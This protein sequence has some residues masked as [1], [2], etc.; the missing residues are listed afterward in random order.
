MNT[1]QQLVEFHIP[2]ANKIAC[3]KKRTL[4]RRITLEELQSAA[5]MGLVEA[6]NRFD[7][8]K[9]V[10]FTTFAYPRVFGAIIDYLRECGIP[11]T[12]LDAA[13]EEEGCTLAE[14]VAAPRESHVEEVFEALTIGMDDRTQSM[15]RCYY[16]DDMSMKDVGVRFGVTESRISQLLSDCRRDIQARCNYEDLAA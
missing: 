8:V 12:S 6:A 13:Y 3:R 4:P 11:I 10:T 1:V 14:I 9:G 15:L 2:F 16:M 5:Y 7:D